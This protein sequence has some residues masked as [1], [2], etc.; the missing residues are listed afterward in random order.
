MTDQ[1][2]RSNRE[3]PYFIL[4]I[5][6]SALIYFIAIVSLVG[7]AI[8]LVIFLISIYALFMSLGYIRANGIRISEKQFPDVYERV[9]HISQEMNLKKVPD[10]FVVYSEGAF[11][12]FAS[13]FLGKH[14]IVLYSE[15]FELARE[16]G[17]A[18]LD[19]IIAHELTHIKRNHVWKNMF[20]MP[21]RLIPFLSQAYSRACE[22]TCDR[23]AAF[24]IQDGAAAKR[25][26]TILS[27]GKKLYKEV[28]EEAYLEQITTESN[29]IVWL[30]EV[31]SSHPTTP[32]R[33]QA[34]GHFMQVEGT[35]HY[36]PN[37]SKIALGIGALAGIFI[38]GYIGVIAI[39]VTG[40]VKYDRFFSGD[41]L[42]QEILAP[43][44][45]TET[46]TLESTATSTEESLNLTPLMEA[47]L[48]YD[49]LTVRKLVANGVNLEERDTENTTALHHAVYKDNIALAEFLLISGA[50]PNTEDLYTNALT[51]SFYYENYDMAA[52]LYKY[53]A[54]PAALDPEGYSGNNIM[55]VNSDEFLDSIS[56]YTSTP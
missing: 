14:M 50:N 46:S 35:P 23:Q 26:L 18:E 11:N 28:N 20:I 52:I 29:V 43:E 27:I 8:L 9:V 33:V 3:M 24:F 5:I 2:L 25:G 6:F 55:E 32:K 39:T 36:Y 37:T 40:A 17:N 19:F 45:T 54:N 16:Q 34:V 47:V 53:G 15:V 51:A 31:L 1:Q 13:F 41:L 21:A 38:I 4:C 42:Q 10:I 12:A 30:S 56:K 7:I 49:E 22:Y 44:A 48:A